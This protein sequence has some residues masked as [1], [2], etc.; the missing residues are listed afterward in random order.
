MSDS[1]DHRPNITKAINLFNKREVEVIIHAG[2]LISPFC[3]DF[4]KEIKGKFY[5]CAGNNAGD[6]K[7]IF[8]TQTH[9]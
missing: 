1:H 5:L 9:I 2:D 3:L 4:F 6:D 7:I 8:L